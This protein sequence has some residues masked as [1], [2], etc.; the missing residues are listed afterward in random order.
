MKAYRKADEIYKAEFAK[1]DAIRKDY[2]AMKCDD[3]AY[4]AAR[5]A[6]EKEQKD[7]DAAWA[8]VA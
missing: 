4:L 3:S 6:F 1:F 2:R 7:F 8:K 5:K